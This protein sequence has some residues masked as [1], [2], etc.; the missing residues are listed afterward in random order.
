MNVSATIATATPAGAR[1]SAGVRLLICD[2]SIFMRMAIRTLCQEHPDIEIV[3]EAKNG[4]EAIDMVARLQP[5]L[6]TMDVDMPGMNGVSATQTIVESHQLPVI[7]LSGL[8]RRRSEMA[9]EFLD[10][11]AVDVIWKSASM[12]DIDI[13]GIAS[14]IIEKVLFWGR[15]LLGPPAEPVARLEPPIRPFDAM[16][17]T[18]GDGGAS[19]LRQ[20]LTPLSN[21]HPPVIVAAQAPASCMESLLRNLSSMAGLQAVQASDGLALRPGQIVLVAGATRFDLRLSGDQMLFQKTSTAL[22]HGAAFGP[23]H[24]TLMEAGRNVLSIALSGT[25]IDEKTVGD[26]APSQAQILV[27]PPETC[28]APEGCATL[29]RVLPIAQA[30]HPAT[31]REALQTR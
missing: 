18:L 24:R 26:L 20:L 3:G 14:I 22:T 31:I 25:S 23:L 4:Q 2:D 9:A 13:G 1:T 28:P 8:T 12:M 21:N 16:M 7:I 5:D 6:V 27:Q 11:G 10:S 17:V 19:A 30:V 29:L 15:P